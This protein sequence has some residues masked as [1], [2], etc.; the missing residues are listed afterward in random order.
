MLSQDTVDHERRMADMGSSLRV[1][2]QRCCFA[3]VGLSWYVSEGSEPWSGV[4]LSRA[5]TMSQVPD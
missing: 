2:A 3:L 1:A 5:K 4:G